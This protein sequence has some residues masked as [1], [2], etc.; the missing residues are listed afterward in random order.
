MPPKRQHRVILGQ[1]IGAAAAVGAAEL[2]T[3]ALL[4]AQSDLMLLW[5]GAAGLFAAATAALFVGP[6]MNPAAMQT[7]TLSSTVRDGM[8]LARTSK[9]NRGYLTTQQLFVPITL[10]VTFYT[11]HMS[12]HG[13]GTPVGLRTVVVWSSA[14]LFVGSFV[15]SRTAGLA[16]VRGMLLLSSLL[17]V[18]AAGL[19]MSAQVAGLWSYA[20]I[21]GIVFMIAAMA[22]QAVYVSGVSWVNLFAAEQG[23][24]T[25]RGFAQA[26]TTL[27]TS[28]AGPLFGMLAAHGDAM[29]SVAT[30][31]ALCVGAVA[32]ATRA[33]A[34]RTPASS[35][36]RRRLAG[37]AQAP[38]WV[39]YGLLLHRGEHKAFPSLGTDR[40][41][42][43]DIEPGMLAH[44]LQHL[45]HT[46]GLQVLGRRLID[47]PAANDVVHQ[48]E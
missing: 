19:C 20:W 31:M 35:A 15:W 46:A 27:I 17:A 42:R 23:R 40:L 32:A 34:R 13:G 2:L 21:H 25:M 8:R 33:P 36:A 16:G 18:G 5:L 29:W 43:R 45:A 48:N 9:W 4:G 6:V 14:G 10:G 47:P 3:P 24:A 22:N 28:L 1:Y 37:G 26:L 41:D 38:A 7:V 11:L 44:H 30:V 39:R 12:T